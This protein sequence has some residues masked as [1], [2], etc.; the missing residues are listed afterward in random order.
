MKNPPALRSFPID[1][2][3]NRLLTP[4]PLLVGVSI[5]IE[6]VSLVVA[7]GDRKDALGFYQPFQRRVLGRPQ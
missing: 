1:N 2:L 4:Y 6:D 5:E 3:C 7:T